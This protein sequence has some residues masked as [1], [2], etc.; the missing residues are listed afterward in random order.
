MHTIERDGQMLGGGSVDSHQWSMQRN[1]GQDASR[2]QDPLEAGTKL[3]GERSDCGT[4]G[5]S[6]QNSSLSSPLKITPK[7]TK[8]TPKRSLQVPWGPLWS[9]WRVSQGS[10][11]TQK[12]KRLCSPGALCQRMAKGNVTYV[13]TRHFP[14]LS[15]PISIV[16]LEYSYFQWMVPFSPRSQN[17]FKMKPGQLGQ[18]DSTVMFS[19]LQPSADSL[20]E[21]TSH[22]QACRE[23]IW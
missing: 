19:E 2:P 4:P 1:R 20:L 13:S 11:K 3:V 7:Q 16:T 10:R 15:Y 22:R 9:R 6:S 12:K 18:F 21:T 8:W 23:S 17:D 5:G 14:R